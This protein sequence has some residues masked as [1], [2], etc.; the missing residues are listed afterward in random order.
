MFLNI[1]LSKNGQI[2]SEQRCHKIDIYL[3]FYAFGIKNPIPPALIN[4]SAKK[5][6]LKV[7]QWA[8]ENGCPE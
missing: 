2:L 6:H 7:L 3:L 1:E 5:G 8:R 4:E